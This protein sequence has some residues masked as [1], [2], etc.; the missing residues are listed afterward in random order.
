MKFQLLLIF[1][2]ATSFT[3]SQNE[4][5]CSDYK[6]GSYKLIIEGQKDTDTTYLKRL[7]S[8]QVE[9]KIKK[10]KKVPVMTL[11]VIWIKDCTY[12]LRSPKNNSNKQ[13]AMKGDVVCK[14][15]EVGDGYY[16]VKAWIYGKSKTKAVY[17]A[18]KE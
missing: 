18:I 12:I 13:K 4:K 16:L 7:E 14:I 17:R 8:V 1:L 11:K 6:L 10:G 3:F 2:I 9:Y 15:I 5:T